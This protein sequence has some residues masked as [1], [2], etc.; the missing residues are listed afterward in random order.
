ME[1]RILLP[2]CNNDIDPAI[3]PTK[4]VNEIDDKLAIQ[5]LDPGLQTTFSTLI[6]DRKHLLVIEYK[7][8][9]SNEACKSIGV[10]TYSN[11]EATIMSYTSIF[12]TLWIR[13]ELRQ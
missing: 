8:G 3:I 7:D 9:G 2:A 1:V 4:C 11:S 13:T 6:V 10:A 12:D 5:F